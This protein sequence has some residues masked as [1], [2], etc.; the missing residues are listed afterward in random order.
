MLGRTYSSGFEPDLEEYLLRRP[1]HAALNPAWPW[2]LWYPLRRKG[3]FALLSRQEQGLV[4]HEHAA[5]GRLYGEA[6]Y[7]HDI[8]LASHGLDQADNDFVIGLTGPE[9][10]PLSRI[11]QE[12]RKSQQTG[13]YIEKLG[14]FFVG[15]AC[16]QSPWP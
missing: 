4:L 5:I 13:K 3:E 1:R 15:K 14:P 10:Y 11:V 9:L 2:A 7:A 8:R 6:G 16:W 12:M